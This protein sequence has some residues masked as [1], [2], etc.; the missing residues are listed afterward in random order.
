MAKQEI[1]RQLLHTHSQCV[2]IFNLNFP[3]DIRD[4]EYFL[5]DLECQAEV[6][7]PMLESLQ[8]S[9]FLQLC[10]SPTFTLVAALRLLHCRRHWHW[11]ANLIGIAALSTSLVCAAAP[12]SVSLVRNHL[13]SLEE[14][15]RM[16]SRQLAPPLAPIT[17]K[18]RSS[19]SLHSR[20]P[21]M[22]LKASTQSFHKNDEHFQAMQVTHSSQRDLTS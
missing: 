19:C 21:C 11:T 3:G 6:P 9:P 18:P 7:A 20:V 5:R 17:T 13:P 22:C 8:A 1:E 4:P 15:T 10:S 14:T 2:R 16:Q 12:C